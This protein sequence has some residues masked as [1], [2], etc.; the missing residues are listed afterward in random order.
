MTQ[1]SQ[2]RDL[3]VEVVIIGYGPVGATLANLLGLRGVRTL[4]LERE[5]AAYHLPR[6]VHFDDEVMRI[7]QTIG[8]SDA[9]NRNAIPSIGMHFV[10]ADGKLI[11]DWSRSS[12]IASQGWHPSYRF[13]QPDLESALRSGLKRWPSVS[14]MT[15]CDVFALEEE[16]CDVVVRFEDLSTGR[17]AKCRAKY[18]VG[19][20]GARS[21]VRRFM[22]VSMDDL[23]FH[24]RWLVIDFL[25]SRPRPDLGDYS[26][27]YCDPTRPATYVRGTNNRRRWEI[28]LLSDEDVH[29]MTTPDRIWPLLR[30]W[31][32]PED[33]AIE[34]AAVYTFHSVVAEHWRVGRLLL[35]G[36]SAHQTPP[37]L[38]QGM[39]AGIRDA[40]NLAWK[41]ADVVARRSPDSLLD[42]YE[43]ERSPHVRE[44]IE[45]AIRLGGIINTKNASVA[46]TALGRKGDETVKFTSAKPRLGPG[47]WI[48]DDSLGGQLAPQP[49]LIGGTQLDHVVGYDF[50]LLAAPAFAHSLSQRAK[51]AAREIGIRIIDDAASALQLWLDQNSVNAALVRPDRYVVGTAMTEDDFTALL[52][53]LP[54]PIQ[55]RH[56]LAAQL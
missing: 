5:S 43:S 28:T 10:D 36:D 34:R 52:R 24:E 30:R 48:S 1:S 41:L 40:S 44:Y 11:L 53:L 49:A 33:G 14:V 13:H 35:A 20:D 50:A 23:G 16:A 31:V 18:V 8:L 39:C 26:V 27:Q 51:A 45:R 29:V 32:G 3:E 15:R 17:L 22:G 21:L 55:S 38:G 54:A 47:L 9:I 42:S 46:L 12:E 37:F 19:C 7:F 56:A 6:A 4:V 2:H 25:L